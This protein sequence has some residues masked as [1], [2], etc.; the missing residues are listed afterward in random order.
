ARRAVGGAAQGAADAVRAAT[1]TTKTKEREEHR[2]PL[3]NYD[4]LTV[5]DVTR[6]LDRLTPAQ[7]RHVATY[8]RAHKRRRGILDEVERREQEHERELAAH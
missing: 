6:R 4:E 7:L 8:E 3:P 2:S 5:E 1:G